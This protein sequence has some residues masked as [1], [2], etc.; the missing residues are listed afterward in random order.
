MSQWERRHMPVTEVT[1]IVAETGVSRR[2]AFRSHAE[3]SHGPAVRISHDAHLR[4]EGVKHRIIGSHAVLDKGALKDTRMSVVGQA[5][6]PAPQP[7]AQP[8]EETKQQPQPVNGFADGVIASL[9]AG[10]AVGA[11]LTKLMFAARLTPQQE[12]ARMK[13]LEELNRREAAR[14]LE[15]RRKELLAEAD[16]HRKRVEARAERERLQAEQRQKALDELNKRAEARNKG[17]SS[18]W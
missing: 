1:R 6:A 16:A 13:A 5:Q 9:A 18:W 2:Q 4:A 17:K 15:A 11:V 12:I 10:V 7:E 8:V 14:N 3:Y